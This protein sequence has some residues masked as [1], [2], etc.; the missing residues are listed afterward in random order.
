MDSQI[1]VSLASTGVAG[2][3]VV[4]SLVTTVLSL[5]AQREN[6]RDAL[7]TQ[8]RLSAAQERALQ[9]RSHAQDLRDKRAEPYLALIKWADRLLEALDELDEVAKPYLSV[10]EWNIT[11]D[12]DSLVDLYAS[13]VI[14]VRYAALRG[15]LIGLVATDGPRLPQLVTWTESEGEVDDVSIETGS[16]WS[17]WPARAEARAQLTDDAIGLIAQVRAEL[18]GRTSRGYFIIWRLS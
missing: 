14:H 7:E 18:Q 11:P 16:P 2:L 10:E 12:V 8:E 3:A 9:K 17:A 15:A 13:D 1:I 4:A 6:T 5:R